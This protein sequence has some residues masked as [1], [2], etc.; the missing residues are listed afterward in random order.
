[1]SVRSPVVFC[2]FTADFDV[3]PVF[4]SYF[5]QVPQGEF[6]HGEIVYTGHR[7]APG[8]GETWSFI[9]VLT[10]NRG[11]HQPGDS[12]VEHLQKYCQQHQQTIAFSAFQNVFPSIDHD[13]IVI[14]PN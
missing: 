9:A 2:V 4:D 6:T 5:A 14:R 8:E 1:M 10:I 12:L 11:Q 7:V 3:R 13:G